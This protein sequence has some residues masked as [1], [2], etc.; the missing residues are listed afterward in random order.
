MTYEASIRFKPMLQDW[1]CLPKI[2][3]FS[4]LD[5]PFFPRSLPV[6]ARPT[7]RTI[8]VLVGCDLV[9]DGLIKLPFVRALK[10]AFPDA[11]LH[12]ITSH[13]KT[14]YS[15]PLRLLVRGLIDEVH[16][17]P[18]W[19]LQAPCPYAFDILIDTRNRWKEALRAKRLPHRYFIAFALRYALSD[20]R[21]SPFNRKPP[22][23][24]DRLM[25]VVTLLTRTKPQPQGAINLPADIMAQA[26]R[27]LPDGGSYIGFAPGAG[28]KTK[29]WPRENF[30]AVARTVSD[31]GFTPVFILGP[32]EVNWQAEL[33][34]AVPA[35]LF[36][37]QDRVAF[38]SGVGVIHTVALG[39]RLKLTVCNDSGT[40][41][42][43]AATDCPLVSLFG[44]TDP[45]K[46]APRVTHRQIIWAKDFGSTEMSAIPVEVVVK[47]IESLN[48]FA[49]AC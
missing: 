3:R 31:Q 12:W 38:N 46:F 36:P 15:G 17:M 22:H 16:E 44:P 14:A 35:A 11:K 27:A 8:G 34:A 21:P 19:L 32:D 28:G 42:M 45:A 23:L 1:R 39:T 33:A 37:L 4:S 20:L 30:I 43:L 25:D 2:K 41:H 48:P 18:D 49:P 10:S 47:A 29:I 5:M 26:E 7:I 13:S 6:S 24:V 40:S 9:G